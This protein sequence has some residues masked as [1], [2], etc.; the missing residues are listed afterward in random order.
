[1]TVLCRLKKI[2]DCENFYDFI[3]RNL[4]DF[5]NVKQDQ[6]R[7]TISLRWTYSKSINPCPFVLK[8][9]A[10]HILYVNICTQ[11]YI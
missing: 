4:Y 5:E 3:L 9:D 2:I 8:L 10:Q 11:I 6:T 1:M 7:I